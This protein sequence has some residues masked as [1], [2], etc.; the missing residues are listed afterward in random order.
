MNVILYLTKCQLKIT[1][2]NKKY[3]K[4]WQSPWIWLR[5]NCGTNSYMVERNKS[6]PHSTTGVRGKWTASTWLQY[7][8]GKVEKEV[9]L[10]I[11]VLK[12]Y[13][14]ICWEFKVYILAGITISSDSANSVGIFLY[15]LKSQLEKRAVTLQIQMEIFYFWMKVPAGETS[16]SPGRDF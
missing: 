14:A 16:C 2:F 13:I 1:L 12:G 10:T 15:L 6:L 11:G 8:Q 7:K 4:M 9:F 3:P 5:N